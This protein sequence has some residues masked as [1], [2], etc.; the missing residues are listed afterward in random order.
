MRTWYR[1]PDRTLHHLARQQWEPASL[2]AP[3]VMNRLVQAITRAPGEW[4][5]RI[6]PS[7]FFHFPGLLSSSYLCPF[8][9]PSWHPSVPSSPFKKGTLPS[10]AAYYPNRTGDRF[11]ARSRGHYKW[12]ILATEVR[13]RTR[14]RLTSRR[15]VRIRADRRPWRSGWRRTI[16]QVWRV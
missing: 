5:D 16:G 6:V 11:I 1:S 3:V 2:P 14:A 9:V 7:P 10:S 13:R 15:S 8:S 12:K 4:A